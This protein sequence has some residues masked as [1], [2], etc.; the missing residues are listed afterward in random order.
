MPPAVVLDVRNSWLRA[1]YAPEGRPFTTVF[2]K[3]DCLK[4]RAVGESLEIDFA[5]QTESDRDEWNVFLN[6]FQ[7]A[8]GLAFRAD[9]RPLLHA[10]VEFLVASAVPSDLERELDLYYV[11]PL[12][13]S[14]NVGSMVPSARFQVARTAV[15]PCDFIDEGFVLSSEVGRF[16]VGMNPKNPI[17][18]RLFTLIDGKPAVLSFL[19]EPGSTPTVSLEGIEAADR[20]SGPVD[21]SHSLKAVVAGDFEPAE[22]PEVRTFARTMLRLGCRNTDFLKMKDPLTP[23]ALTR[24]IRPSLIQDALVFEIRRKLYVGITDTQLQ[25]V[26]GLQCTEE[27]PARFT[28]PFETGIEGDYGAIVVFAGYCPNPKFCRRSAPIHIQTSVH[29]SSFSAHLSFS[30]Y[31]SGTLE[32]QALSPCSCSPDPKRDFVIP[33]LLGRPLRKG[34]EQT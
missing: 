3:T 27:V 6:S 12:N 32:I 19:F 4:I 15:R 31:C 25:A 34:L 8:D 10:F 2:R 14:E 11:L 23:G 13:A 22:V 30:D 7:L 9:L 28:I 1:L 29:G 20:V 33:G 26:V 21:A 5:S 16:M 18:V 24:L 17:D